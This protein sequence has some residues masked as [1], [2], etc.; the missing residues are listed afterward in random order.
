MYI[1]VVLMCSIFLFVSLAFL[2]AQ[3]YLPAKNL[4]K[5][6]T[7]T[8]SWWQMLTEGG[9]LTGGDGNEDETVRTRYLQL[10]FGPLTKTPCWCK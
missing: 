6:A 5:L 8:K 7:T 10:V 1:Y 9:A 4:A 3:D 2:S